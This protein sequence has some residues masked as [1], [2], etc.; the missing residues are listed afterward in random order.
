MAKG[1]AGIIAV[2][3][4]G[5]GAMPSKDEEASEPE[6]EESDYG[7]ELAEILGVSDEDREDFNAALKGF[8]K[9]CIASDEE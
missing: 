1:L 3:P 7:S 2:L 5:K 4:K 8:V 9:K 6:A